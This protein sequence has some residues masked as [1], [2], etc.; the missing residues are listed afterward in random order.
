MCLSSLYVL[1]ITVIKSLRCNAGCPQ[2]TAYQRIICTG[3]F[4]GY[5]E[6]AVCGTMCVSLRA[7]M[8]TMLKIAGVV[9]PVSA[10][11]GGWLKIRIGVSL[12]LFGVWVIGYVE[13][14]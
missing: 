8:L 3:L 10:L 2:R 13:G 12:F 4:V 7:G 14:N 6:I 1:P 9:C 5:C 11:K